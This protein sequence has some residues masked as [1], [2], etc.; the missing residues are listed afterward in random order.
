MSPETL[1]FPEFTILNVFKL[2]PVYI[3]DLFSTFPLR[4]IS[5]FACVSPASLIFDALISIPLSELASSVWAYSVPFISIPFPFILLT[6]I[7]P[8]A[9]IS[10]VVSLE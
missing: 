1:I 3:F 4:F 5:S 9:V 10:S 2:P 8:S 7:I 6:L